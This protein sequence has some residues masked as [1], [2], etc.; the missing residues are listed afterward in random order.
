MVVCP[1]FPVLLL[2][3]FERFGPDHLNPSAILAAD[4]HRHE[5]A[6]GVRIHSAILPVSGIGAWRKMARMIKRY[7]PHW[8]VA[9]GLSSR[10]EITPETQAVNLCDYAIPDCHG[11]QLR[12][13]PVLTRKCK[14]NVLSTMVDIAAMVSV[15]KQGGAPA[16]S[17]LDAGRYVCNNLYFRLLHQSM[18]P[19]YS[20]F[21]RCV[22]IHVPRL[23][24]M[25]GPSLSRDMQRRALLAAL[26]Q[27]TA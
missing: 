15:M 6:G 18:R 10:P 12:G 26:T 14:V 24:E 20:A 8:V 7:Q 1:E 25:G 2:T 11:L 21:G 4:L 27:L 9:L 5:L 3:G 13:I 19:G 17:S 16:S 23:P 22:F